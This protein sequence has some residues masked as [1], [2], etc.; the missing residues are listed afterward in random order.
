MKNRILALAATVCAIGIFISPSAIA[1][2]IT[3]VGTISQTS[4][5]S[6]PPFVAANRQLTGIAAQF[7]QQEAAQMKAATS[8]AQ[9]QQI[10][11]GFSQR[12]TDKQNEILGPL[13]QR[14]QL[15]LA[16]VSSTRKLSVVIDRRIVVYGGQDVT[17][18]VVHLFTGTAAIPQAASTPPPSEIGYVDQTVLD[19]GLPKVK[20][21]NTAF[22]AYA[23]QQRTIFAAK[24]Q[25]A[26][27]AAAK[28]QISADFNKAL[29]D[30]QNKLLNPL[31]KQV[32]GVTASIASKKH[33]LVVID[34]GDVIF[35]GTDIT[36]DV[37]DALS[38]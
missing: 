26:K 16:D 23:Q 14:V 9:R 33:L 36:Q 30:E 21:A 32:R 27:T 24:L 34:K 19:S 20:D 4:L 18:D 25:Q 6:L 31:V 11:L 22:T 5:A 7:Q 1:A 12:F 8:D 35:G 29:S 3:D 13:I 17:S 37:K 10:Q 38:K 2:D 28:A 15:A